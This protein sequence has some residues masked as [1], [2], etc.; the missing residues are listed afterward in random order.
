M[1]EATREPSGTSNGRCRQRSTWPQHGVMV[2]RLPALVGARSPS[3]A[4]QTRSHGVVHRGGVLKKQG[5]RRDQQLLDA[6]GQH[7]KIRIFGNNR[8]HNFGHFNRRNGRC[9][10]CIIFKLFM[11]GRAGAQTWRWIRCETSAN[12]FCNGKSRRWPGRTADAGFGRHEARRGHEPWPNSN[13]PSASPAFV[14]M[15]N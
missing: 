6:F 11:P 8:F 15:L 1:S 3:A 5:F 10:G 14:S 9:A 12:E 4:G 2:P 7:L 13:N